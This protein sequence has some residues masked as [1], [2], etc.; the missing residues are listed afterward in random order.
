MNSKKEKVIRKRFDELSLR[1][2]I[3]PSIRVYR[4]FKSYMKRD[5]KWD[6]FVQE[7]LKW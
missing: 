4:V 5:G 6:E 1:N 2:K 7:A 3:E